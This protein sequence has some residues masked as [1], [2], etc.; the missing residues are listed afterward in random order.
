MKRTTTWYR[1]GDARI[2]GGSAL[3]PRTAWNL[4]EFYRVSASLS[5][6]SRVLTSFWEFSR[7]CASLREFSRVFASFCEFLRVFA[8]FREFSR[9]LTSFG[10]FWASF[11]WVLGVFKR[12]LP[13]LFEL[14]RVFPS[15]CG[16][17]ACDCAFFSFLVEVEVTSREFSGVFATF[18]ELLWVFASFH[19]FL[20]VLVSEFIAKNEVSSCRRR[21]G[22]LLKMGG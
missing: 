5:E 6:F 3:T 13:S 21:G 8:S 20:R 17:C 7:V 11:R 18:C 19:K 15:D 16:V 4:I 9:V 1:F 14:F 2:D 12:V 22:Q 10:E